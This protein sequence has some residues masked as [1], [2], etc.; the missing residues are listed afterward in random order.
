MKI[1]VYGESLLTFTSSNPARGMLRSLLKLRPLDDF[2]LVVRRGSENS[3]VLKQFL[4]SC[5]NSNWQLIVDPRTRKSVYIKALLGQKNYCQISE[6]A[7]V[8]LDLDMNYL[9]PQ[10]TPLIATVA[11]LSSVCGDPKHSSLNWYGRAIRKHALKTMVSSAS[12]IVTISNFTKQSLEKYQ[13][14]LKDKITV[15][16]NGIDDSWRNNSYLTQ[17]PVENNLL[18]E[19]PYWIWWGCITK[20]KNIDGLIIAY[21]Q[22]RKE[23]V[24]STIPDLVLIGQLSSYSH[25]IINLIKKLNLKTN[26]HLISSQPL[27]KLIIYVNQSC[28]LLFPSHYEGF[29][30]PIIEAMTLGKPVLISNRSALPEISGGLG[31]ICNPENHHDICQAM[32]QMLTAKQRNQDAVEAR[33]KWAAN[34]T[35]HIAAQKYSQIIDDVTAKKLQLL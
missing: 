8:Y 22:L 15:I 18:L 34:F 10:A 26:V 1:C 31:V 29:G 24:D 9:G 28:G 20:R 11:D 23:L 35:H 2:L 17:K 21:N 30:M 33:K 7:D 16:Y 4:D 19:K 6:S 12:K 25:N 27:D 14:D 3:P 13:P 5:P 32:K